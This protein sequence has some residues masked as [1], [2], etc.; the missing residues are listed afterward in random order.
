MRYLVIVLLLT[1]GCKTKPH[2][3]DA[4]SIDFEPDF[5]KG[6]PTLVYKT[7]KDYHDLVPVWLSED[8]SRIVAYPGINDIRTT[9]GFPLPTKLQHG[10]FLDN[11]G[12]TKNA[13]FLKLTYEEYAKLDSLPSAKEMYGWIINKDPIRTLCDCG[14]RHVFTDIES[15]LNALIDAGSLKKVCHVLK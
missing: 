8:K 13:A 9:S 4:G 12:I 1:V 5:S 6:P 15:Q 3:A 10:Y 11:R 7:K 14:S 2:T